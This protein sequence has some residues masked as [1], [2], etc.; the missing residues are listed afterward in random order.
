MEKSQR[1]C[2]Q[3]WELYTIGKPHDCKQEPVK[4]ACVSVKNAVKNGGASGK[5]EAGLQD[6]LRFV[7]G[8]KSAVNVT[9]VAVRGKSTNRTRKW[10]EVNREESRN[11]MRDYMRKRR[12]K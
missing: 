1:R 5:I 11:Y 9:L 8:D 7:P 3:C 6:A 2:Q 10:R 12:S 4:N